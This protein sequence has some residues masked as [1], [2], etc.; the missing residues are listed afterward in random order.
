MAAPA[1]DNFVVR[2]ATRGEIELSVDWAAAEGWNPGL[3]DAD[4]FHAADPTGFLLGLADGEPVATISVVKY[5]AD[6]AFLGFYIVRPDFRGLGLGLKTWQAGMASLAG[7][8]VGL[9]GVVAQQ[10]NYRKSGFELAWQNV[11]HEGVAG[12]PAKRD[13]HIVSLST[14]PFATVQAYDQAFFPADREAF[15]QCWIRQPGST[16]LGFVEGGHLKGYGMLRPCR[17][18]F[19]VA[20]LFADSPQIAEALF[21]A[22]RSCAPEGA[23]IYLDTPAPNSHAIELAR[24]HG[25]QPVFE[26]A[27]MYTGRVPKVPMERLYGITSFELG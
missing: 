8:A 14:L 15:L 21:A 7:R 2:I 12:K 4:C 18:G 11:R 20:P 17:A 22:L 26:T 27:R 16:A 23:A 24:R 3:H 19:K 25:M 6:F 13:E 9:D 10:D 1:P 5:G